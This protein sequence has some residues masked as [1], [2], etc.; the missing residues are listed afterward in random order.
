MNKPFLM[1][2]PVV[3]AGSIN[4]AFAN[5]TPPPMGMVGWW[6]GDGDTTDVVNGN[7]GVVVGSV[8]YSDPGM[9]D[10]AFSMDGGHVQVARDLLLEPE[11]VTVDA[12]VKASGTPGAFRYIAAKGAEMCETASYA[13]YTGSTGG[14][15]FYLWDGTKVGDEYKFL[16]S[17]GVLPDAIWDGAWHHV[18]G[19]FDGHFARLYVDGVQIGDGTPALADNDVAIAYGLATS[20]DFL[21]GNYL[22]AACPSSDFSFANGEIDEVEVFNGALASEDIQKIYIAGSDGKC[23]TID[24]AIDIKPG[25]GNDSNCFNNDGHG[26]ITVA[27]LGDEDF[28]V[29]LIDP[30]SLLFGNLSLRIRGKDRPLCS[31]DYA[32][33]DPYLDLVCHFE[34]NAD[35]WLP[36]D[37]AATLTGKLFDGHSIEGSDSICIVP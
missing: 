8:S 16:I 12:W 23:K 20:N 2:L 15:F 31:V 35:A 22:N 14:L 17:P 28:D 9:V 7:N 34:D 18:A 11:A 6:P 27:I 33:A 37:S 13:L 25:N 10:E 26:V 36:G 21:I 24:V 30:S 3:L 29:T 19:T 4:S 32:N 1:L 5:C